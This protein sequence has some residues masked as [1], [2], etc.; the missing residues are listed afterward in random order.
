MLDRKQRPR[1]PAESDRLRTAASGGRTAP[2]S[3]APTARQV[4]RLQR[5]VGNAAVTNWIATGPPT[6]VQRFA[7]SE[8]VNLGNTA[9]AEHL[10]IP[11][12]E[13]PTHHLSFGEVVAMAGDYFGSE[14]EM[15]SLSR[16]A[17]GRQQ[18]A[19]AR[20]KV[21]GGP[22]PAVSAEAKKAVNDRYFR[23][24]AHN[25][26]HFAAGGS[27]QHDY[28]QGHMLAMADAY[29][30]GQQNDE[31]YFDNALDTE[32]FSDHFLTDA[33]SGGHIRTPRRDIQ[34]Y[35]R[36]HLGTSVELMKGFIRDY[37]VRRLNALNPDVLAK[38]PNS[39]IGGQV[40]SML[41][42]MAGSALDSFS[43]GDLVSLAMH[44]FDNE[45]GVPVVSACDLAGNLLP[46]GYHW[47]AFGDNQ[48]GNGGSG[49]GATTFAMAAAATQASRQDLDI[50]RALGARDQ[51][52]HI[53]P[54]D[55]NAAAIA[56]VSTLP[57]SKALAYIPH[58][59]TSVTR[60]QAASDMSDGP[61]GDWRWGHFTPPMRQAFEHGV[62]SQV[63]PKIQDA[64]MQQPEPK[65]I[66]G[67]LTTIHARQAIL[68]LAG[69]IQRAPLT[70]FESIF[71][72]ASP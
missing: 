43:L 25:Q 23:L 3:G 21:T 9:S 7:S 26:S 72:P 31:T 41:N 46:D 36:A 10:D 1:T 35:Y 11:Y 4:L 62:V 54:L 56:A 59:D 71:G 33:F 60:P 19:F 65:P 28:E 47:V 38:V 6:A 67:G 2:V 34:D 20:A 64:G 50:A 32:A 45:R 57:P 37:L 40:D 29:K 55:L 66:L 8:H 14:Q 13:D 5:A 15:E 12:D 52:R 63:A 39:V 42:D 22:E 70:T 18:L 68:D 16:T 30:A 69:Q 58:E 51:S 61:L 49:P 27:A 44:D 17:E 48:I 24:A 53:H